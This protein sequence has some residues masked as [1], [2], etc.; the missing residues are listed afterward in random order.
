MVLNPGST[1]FTDEI[2]TQK[3]TALSHYVAED[4]PQY[5]VLLKYK[6]DFIN[7]IPAQPTMAEM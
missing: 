4:G 5:R 1:S 7:D 2:N 6:D 3:E